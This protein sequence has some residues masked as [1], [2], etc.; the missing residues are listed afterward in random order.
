MT[1]YK[2]SGQQA[3]GKLTGEQSASIWTRNFI[4]LCFGNL[5]L[6][7]SIQMLLPTL[8][9]Y[10]LKIG[11]KQSD[12]GYV[13]GFYVIGAMLIRIIAGWLLDHFSRRKITIIGATIMAGITL[14]YGLVAKNIPLLVVIR[15]LHGLTFG[16]ISTANGTMVADS[17]PDSRM[18]E[19]IGYFGLASTLS[20]ALAPMLGLWLI[21]SFSYSVLFSAVGILAL[22]TLF[23][24]YFLRN[25]DAP[26]VI[27][28]NCDSGTLTSLFDKTALMPSTLAF[29]QALMYSA[30][31]Y[32][33]ALYA[34]SL[35]ISNVGLFF[36]AIA[37]TMLISRPV[38]GRWA[39][40]GGTDMILL[41]SLLTLSIGIIIIGFYQT[42]MGLIWPVCLLELVLGF[43]FQLYSL[44]R[45]VMHQFIE[46][47]L[48]LVLSLW[49]MTWAL[50]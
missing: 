42:Y 11:G 3:E 39:D 25:V 32:Y 46:E 26:A 2:I 35:G 30:V 5:C 45:C 6:F 43:A 40:R 27:P 20:I 10:T 17:L 41:I 15:F 19:G 37:L 36:A 1:Q 4:L 48:Q 47:G 24:I 18:G 29:F 50:A 8:P 23:C 22:L 38:S 21:T 16:F 14:L 49:P 9:L 7:I 12:V 28:A 13:M 44:W 31:L 34:E 33:I